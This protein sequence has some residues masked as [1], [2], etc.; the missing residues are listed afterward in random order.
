MEIQE[1]QSRICDEFCRYQGDEEKCQNCPLDELN[2][3][4]SEIQQY[5]TIGTVAEC[6]EAMEK[7]MAKKPNIDVELVA[8]ISF[9]STPWTSY[10]CQDCGKLIKG[11]QKAKYCFNCGCRIDWIGYE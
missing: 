4:D 11:R 3:T 6:R 10:Y 7:H 1:I 2:V 8:D 5:R 9:G